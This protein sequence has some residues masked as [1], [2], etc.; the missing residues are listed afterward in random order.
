MTEHAI[1]RC[2]ISGGPLRSL[3]ATEL[4]EANA[5]RSHETPELSAGYVSADGQYAYP[6]DDG[7]SR[8]TPDSAIS[9]NGAAP[10]TALRAEKES[11]QA[12]YDS[13]G[14]QKDEEG[15]FVDTALFIDPNPSIE[16]YMARCR[17]RVQDHLPK[18]GSYLLD[19]ASGPVQFPEYQAYSESFAHRVCVDLS[20]VAL[21]EARRN[22]GEDGVYVVGD[23]TNLPFQDDSLD[24]VSSLHTLYHVPHDEQAD[25]FREI[26]RVLKPGG[27]AVIVYFWQTTPWR[28]RS[29]PMK[30]AL[31]PSRVVR[32]VLAAVRGR[33]ANSSSAAKNELYYHA[34]DIQWFEQQN[35][36]FDA[37]LRSWSSVNMDFL[38]KFV[39]KSGPLSRIPAAIFWAEERFP[40]LLGR[41]G[42]YPMIVI[43][44]P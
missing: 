33:S 32:R 34:H 36:P 31:L 30:I 25:A 16:T 11:V 3:T 2:P 43:R 20:M 8:L 9:L 15:V 40:S 41:I 38:R 24:G 1:L 26:Y 22:V 42:R 14:W 12:F 28:N 27:T 4:S 21:Q 37:D 19:V 17:A 35:F 7:I 5:R 13:K 10:D 23:V 18:S 44:K 39:P 6:V 29:L